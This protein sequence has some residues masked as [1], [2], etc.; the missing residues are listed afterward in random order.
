MNS[1]NVYSFTS[2]LNDEN[3]NFKN[4]PLIVPVLYNM[5]KQSL[6][7]PKLYYSISIE[8]TIDVNTK[9]SQDDILTL[10]SGDESVIP[11]QQT[12]S[13]KVEIT[14]NEYPSEAGIYAVKN[15]ETILKHLSFNYNRNESNLSY[16]DL[17]SIPNVTVSN[18]LNSTLLGIK[19]ATNVNELWK[20]FVIF[21]LAFL[22]MEM[23]ILKFFK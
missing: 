9:L 3:S 6:K 23:L 1:K 11:L 16:F 18:N 13:N 7:L 19:S 15:K 22:I 17:S 2:A 20:W 12:Y 5:G 8:N 21:A 10:N 4:S 14:T